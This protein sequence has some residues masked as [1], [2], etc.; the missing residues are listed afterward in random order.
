VSFGDVLNDPD[1]L[2]AFRELL[3]KE[4]STENLDFYEAVTK[5]P[6]IADVKA[7]VEAVD[8]FY[9]TYVVSNSP[10]WVNLPASQQAEFKKVI[11]QGE[12]A[13]DRM[14]A[15]VKRTQGEIFQLM[16]RDPFKRFGRT[17]RGK[18]VIDRL[19]QVRVYNLVLRYVKL[20]SHTRYFA[21]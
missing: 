3:E 1:S 6:P 16:N 11:E 7:F 18:E 17:E 2:S 8:S 4:M 14:E 5:L 12:S 19:K 13:L 9:Q 15:I 21:K 10:G 20:A